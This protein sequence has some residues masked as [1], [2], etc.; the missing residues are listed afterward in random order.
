MNG[1]DLHLMGKDKDADDFTDDM[2]FRDNITWSKGRLKRAKILSR[3]SGRTYA[4]CILLFYRAAL[5]SM[6]GNII[7]EKNVCLSVCLSNA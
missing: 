3:I 2:L 7:H 6:Q 1:I 5:H 4:N